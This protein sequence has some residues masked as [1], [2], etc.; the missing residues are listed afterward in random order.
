MHENLYN[1]N[2]WIKVIIL[3][4]FYVMFFFVLKT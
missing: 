4:D 3:F 1:V 2:F